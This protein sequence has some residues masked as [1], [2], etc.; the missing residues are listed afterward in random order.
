MVSVLASVTLMISI[1]IPTFGRD[2]VLTETV[3][4]L[5]ALQTRADE[6]LVIDQTPTHDDETHGKLESWHR[7]G[8]IR[9]I[10]LERPSITRSMNHALREAGSSHVLF[11]DDDIR[12][13]AEIVAVH[14]RHH[15]EHPETWATVGQVIQP[16]QEPEDIDAPRRSKG[17]RV[18]EDFPFHSSRDLAVENVMAGNLCVHRER[19]LS[20]GGFDE[21]FVGAA[22][23]FETEFAKRIVKAGG[24]IQFLGG[25]GIDHLRAERGG[26][27]STGS[28]LTSADPKHGVGDHYYAMLHAETRYQAR[29]YCFRR[30]LREVRTKF[31]L[32]HPWWIPVKLTGE[33][34]AYMQAKRLVR[35]KR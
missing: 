1:A 35:E 21:N 25:A 30:I 24:S 27:R 15:R 9:W 7:H 12:P 28:H 11:L 14:Q 5:L 6:L 34:R 2:Q 29:A 19:A 31:H 8:E 3:E 17:L 10:R 23:R 18:D 32:K 16:W 4:S 13:R 26:T 33:I 22:Y 20:I